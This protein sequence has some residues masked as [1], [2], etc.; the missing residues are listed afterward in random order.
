[1]EN[2]NEIIAGVGRPAIM[3]VNIPGIVCGED[4]GFDP[5]EAH[6]AF[7][8]V[9]E[10]LL[11]MDMPPSHED[12]T[13]MVGLIAEYGEATQRLMAGIRACMPIFGVVTSTA[14]FMLT[15]D[16]EGCSRLAE[17]MVDAMEELDR[18]FEAFTDHM[19]AAMGGFLGG[20]E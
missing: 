8:R 2:G 1:M 7:D 11:G 20:G 19:F 9:G 18:A 4:F 12:L 10:M 5:D 16:A 6:E 13:Q 14:S 17:A 3:M 15:D